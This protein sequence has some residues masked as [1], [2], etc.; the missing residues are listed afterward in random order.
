[1][2][3]RRKVLIYIDLFNIKRASGTDP[4]V[5]RALLTHTAPTSSQRRK[6]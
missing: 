2:I 3:N 1:M 4:E 5:V 6:R